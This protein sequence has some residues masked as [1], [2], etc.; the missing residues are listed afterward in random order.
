MNKI[1][2][3][4]FSTN[5]YEKKI[6]NIVFLSAGMPVLIVVGVFY[7]LFSDLVYTYLNSGMAD[8]FL[9]QFL[10][11]SIIILLYY[12]LFVGIIAYRFIHRLVGAFPR[13]LR[14]LDERIAGKSRA[15]IHLRQGD[16]ARELVNRINALIDKLPK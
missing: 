13:V 4:P 7:C 9:Y 1:Y 3:R 5:P 8:H 16:Y 12:F 14:E 15:H 11:L 6:L 10:I 2:R